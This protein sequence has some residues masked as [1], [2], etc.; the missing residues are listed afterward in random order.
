MDVDEKILSGYY[1]KGMQKQFAKLLNDAK[2]DWEA[3]LILRYIRKFD[4]DDEEFYWCVV[5]GKTYRH[6]LKY[7]LAK[8]YF[9]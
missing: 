8:K 6:S 3:G 7:L 2:I 1:G 9:L 5:A 4:L